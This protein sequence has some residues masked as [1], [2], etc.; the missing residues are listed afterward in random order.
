MSADDGIT[1]AIPGPAPID[2]L[3]PAKEHAPACGWRCWR[4]PKIGSRW[5]APWSWFSRS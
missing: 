2:E 4:W 1:A 5:R 3:Q